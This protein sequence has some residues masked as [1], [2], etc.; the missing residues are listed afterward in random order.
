LGRGAGSNQETVS[1]YSR[2][3][4]PSVSSNGVRVDTEVAADG[5]ESVLDSDQGPLAHA[6][7]RWAKSPKGE[8]ARES[9]VQALPRTTSNNFPRALYFLDLATDRAILSS[10][11][12]VVNSMFLL[13]QSFLLITESVIAPL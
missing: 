13:I 9:H 11:K 6:E 5:V 10:L 3:K 12:M 1:T 7:Q 8:N 2:P 4:I